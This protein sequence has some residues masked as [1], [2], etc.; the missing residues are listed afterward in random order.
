M[1]KKNIFLLFLFLPNF[2]LTSQ[3]TT[4]KK[5]SKL[6]EYVDSGILPKNTIFACCDEPN[7][8]ALFFALSRLPKAVYPHIL[9]EIDKILLRSRICKCPQA[10]INPS[11]PIESIFTM[12]DNEWMDV[13]LKETS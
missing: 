11:V 2:L 3:M 1:L 10:R 6:R 12:D 13:F 5:A 9:I 7:N 8:S 4:R